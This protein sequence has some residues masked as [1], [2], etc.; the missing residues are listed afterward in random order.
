MSSTGGPELRLRLCQAA[1]ILL[2]RHRLI[3]LKN[4]R[5]ARYRQFSGIRQQA[6]CHLSVLPGIL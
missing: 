4:K 1:C 6:I 3:H 2:C 5:L